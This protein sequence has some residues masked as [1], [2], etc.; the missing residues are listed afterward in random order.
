MNSWFGTAFILF[1]CVLWFAGFG[2]LMYGVWTLLKSNS[3]K[4]WPETTGKVMSVKLVESGRKGSRMVAAEYSYVVDSREYIG[5]RIAFGYA[6]S[7]QEGVHEALF[8]KLRSAK[9][10]VV[11]YDPN[12][13]SIS[14]LS[15][16][17]NSSIRLVLIF[18]IMF[19]VLVS[20]VI[21]MV[22]IFDSGD[23]VFIDT[24]RVIS[25]T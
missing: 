25:D 2:M 19:L 23:P 6:S 21:A 17:M 20:G 13:Y 15:Y 7:N 8:E 24:I 9:S 4:S 14:A 3:V 11:Q 16:G 10:V 1:L 5:Q 18:S 22:Y 12:N